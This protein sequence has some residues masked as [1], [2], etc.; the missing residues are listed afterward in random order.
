MIC[1]G[2]KIPKVTNEK[3]LLDEIRKVDNLDINLRLGNYDCQLKANGVW[4]SIFV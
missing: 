4:R 2:S 1:C 3:G